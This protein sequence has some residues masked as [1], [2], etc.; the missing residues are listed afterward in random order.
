MPAEPDKVRS[1]LKYFEQ[2]SESKI[3]DPP[4]DLRY[5]RPHDP[6]EG[7]SSDH[8]S[9]G[10]KA[11]T[12]LGYNTVLGAARHLTLKVKKPLPPDPTGTRPS[13]FWIDHPEK[14]KF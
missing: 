13:N 3:E 8:R 12:V 9:Q 6:K 11:E 1:N 7:Y 2:I 10:R 14:K 5:R 4:E